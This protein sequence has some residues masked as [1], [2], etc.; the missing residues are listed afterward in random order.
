MIQLGLHKINIGINR[1]SSQQH[2]SISYS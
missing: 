2:D 1:V